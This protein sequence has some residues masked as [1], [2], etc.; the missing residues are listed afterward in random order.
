MPYITSS[1]IGHLTWPSSTIEYGPN[2][3]KMFRTK[4]YPRPANE[5]VTSKQNTVLSPYLMTSSAIIAISLF[6]SLNGNC[7]ILNNVL[8]VSY[9]ELIGQDGGIV[10]FH[11]RMKNALDLNPILSNRVIFRFPHS[12][13]SQEYGGN[14]FVF[15]F[16]DD[17]K[18]I[19]VFLTLQVRN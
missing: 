13:Q 9:K 16:I 17:M 8:V 1:H 3:G 2:N 11:F 18:A 7:F 12:H 15:P 14:G 6:S 4:T 10:V 5:L 19:K